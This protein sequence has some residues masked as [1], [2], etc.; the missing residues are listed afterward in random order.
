MAACRTA[1]R[2][3]RCRRSAGA[4]CTTID[5]AACIGRR[6]GPAPITDQLGRLARRR[7]PIRGGDPGRPAVAPRPGRCCAVLPSPPCDQ[8]PGTSSSSSG[9]ASRW[10]AATDAAVLLALDRRAG[11]RRRRLCR[12]DGGHHL[13]GRRVSGAL[14]PVGRVADPDAAGRVRAVHRPAGLLDDVAQLVRDRP[15]TG[16]RRRVVLAGLEHDVGA[17]GVCVRSDGLGRLRRPVVG[18]DADALE[19]LPERRLHRR[20]GCPRRGAIPRPTRPRRAPATPAPPRRPASARRPR[21]RRC[22]GGA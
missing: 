22:A 15:L 19:R 7:G 5:E 12:G 3:R 17:H 16:R 20:A 10:T 9:V 14:E 11:A 6:R 8:V 13:V 21:F 18:V 4:P 2:R 1:T